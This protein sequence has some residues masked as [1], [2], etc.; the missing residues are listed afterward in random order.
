MQYD[1]TTKLYET[2]FLFKQGFYNYFYVTVDKSKK[3]NITD[4]N[5]SFYQTENDYQVLV[6]Y[7]KFGAKYDQ[8]IGLGIGNSVNLQN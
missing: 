8:V 5:G 7:H 2:S 3:I 4:I 6:Y 1:D